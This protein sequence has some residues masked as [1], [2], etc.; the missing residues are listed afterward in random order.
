VYGEAIAVRELRRH[1][2]RERGVAKDDL[3]ISGYWRRGR[4]EEGFR[5][6][7]AAEREREEAAAATG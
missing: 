2:T 6:F 3:S 5:Q 1:L 7:K 4:D